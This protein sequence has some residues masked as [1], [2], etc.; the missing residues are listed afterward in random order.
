MRY[1]IIT[2]F[3]CASV[4]QLKAQ[5][6]QD[7]YCYMVKIGVKHPEVVLK[8]AIYESGH[9]RSHIYQTKNNLFGFRN[10]RYITYDT[11]QSCVD[12]YKVWQNK[13]YTNDSLDYYRFIQRMNFSGKNR[14]RYVSQ[15]KNTR[16]K[17]NLNCL[18]D[19]EQQGK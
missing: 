7:I 13:H 1:V 6:E 18:A 14:Q 4:S 19:D 2:L 5:K 12:Y 11:W 15:L 8:Q 10:K 16:I 9:F 3:F 17:A